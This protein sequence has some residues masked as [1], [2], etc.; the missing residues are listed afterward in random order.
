MILDPEFRRDDKKC[1]E[2]IRIRMKTYQLLAGV[3]ALYL[4]RIKK[5][6]PSTDA[7]SSSA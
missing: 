6:V 1:V 7:E 4:V 5:D 3:H 2:M